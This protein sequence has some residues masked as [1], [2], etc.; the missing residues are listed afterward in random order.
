MYDWSLEPIFM[1]D[2]FNSPHSN[3][4]L[5]N[6]VKPVECKVQQSAAKKVPNESSELQ[7]ESGFKSQCYYLHDLEQITEPL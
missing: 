3:L 7:P 2:F 4:G 6:T 5:D 1:G